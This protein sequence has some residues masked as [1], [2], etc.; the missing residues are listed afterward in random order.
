MSMLGIP[1][2]VQLKTGEQRLLY[3]LK[4]ASTHNIRMIEQFRK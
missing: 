4:F 2:L 3:K 1:A